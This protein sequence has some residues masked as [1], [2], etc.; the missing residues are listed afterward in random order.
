VPPQVTPFSACATS[1]KY[2]KQHSTLAT[3]GH[4]PSRSRKGQPNLWCGSASSPS[5]PTRLVALFSIADDQEPVQGQLQPVTCVKRVEKPDHISE[6]ILTPVSV[7]DR[8]SESGNIVHHT[9]L[10]RILQ[11]LIIY[12]T[13]IC[14]YIDYKASSFVICICLRQLLKFTVE[15]EQYWDLNLAVRFL[16]TFDPEAE[17]REMRANLL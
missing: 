7:P 11:E 15:S 2:E 16:A 17:R 6:V 13:T 1:R 5:I 12:N 10:K 14:L 4:G 8:N 9:C 3:K